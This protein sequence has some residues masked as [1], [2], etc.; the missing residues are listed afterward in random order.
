MNEGANKTLFFENIKD[1]R[2]LEK[3]RQFKP[4]VVYQMQIDDSERIFK[5]EFVNL[6]TGIYYGEWDNSTN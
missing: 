2:I 3:L 1:P 5:D 6:S 4:F